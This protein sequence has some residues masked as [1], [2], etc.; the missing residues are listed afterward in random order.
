IEKVYNKNVEFSYYP[1]CAR[2]R[3]RKSEND[4]FYAIH[5]LY[6]PP[7]NRGNVCLLEDFPPLYNTEISLKVGEEIKR[8]VLVPQNKEIK[9]EQKDG[10]VIFNVEKMELHQLVVLEY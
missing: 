2:V 9:F 5:M 7:V 8:V 1:S 6:A 10:K 3:I 4:N